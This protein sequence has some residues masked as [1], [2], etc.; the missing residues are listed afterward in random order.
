MHGVLVGT[1]ATIYWN[2]LFECI[3]IYFFG[4]FFLS[5]VFLS[6][7]SAHVN[8]QSISFVITAA[9]KTKSARSPFTKYRWIEMKCAQTKTV[10]FFSLFLIEVRKKR[11]NKAIVHMHMHIEHK[12]ND[13]RERKRKKHYTNIDYKANAYN[14]DAY[15]DL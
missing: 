13:R 9:A 14:S 10:F 8:I 12:T 3:C 4:F 2:I 6:P 5:Y 11:S 15:A 7:L 1:A